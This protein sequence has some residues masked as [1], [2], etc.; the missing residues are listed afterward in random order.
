MYQVST[1]NWTIWSQ[2]TITRTLIGVHSLNLLSKVH[3]IPRL[4]RAYAAVTIE[5]Y[6]CMELNPLFHQML[7]RFSPFV[8]DLQFKDNVTLRFQ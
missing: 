5:R 4:I 3:V 8:T 2:W 7:K 1:I 6:Q